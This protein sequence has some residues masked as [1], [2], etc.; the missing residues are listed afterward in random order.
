MNEPRD[1]STVNLVRGSLLL[2]EA[3]ELHGQ[4][5]RDAASAKV[6]EHLRQYRDDPRGLALLGKF[7]LD[8]GAFGQAEHFLG[9]AIALGNTTFEAKR[10]LV[11][12]LLYQE[13]LDEAL[14]AITALSAVND[15]AQLTSTRASILDRLGRHD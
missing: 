14:D 11:S 5:K 6:A 1:P 7:A 10:D 2:A 8:E 13:I 12:A 15:D 4:G 3:I 9:R